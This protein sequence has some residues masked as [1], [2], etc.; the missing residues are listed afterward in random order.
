[1]T[2]REALYMLLITF[3]TGIF[4]ASLYF[5]TYVFEL[6]AMPMKIITGIIAGIALGIM[7]EDIRGAVLSTAIS[8]FMFMACLT[9]LLSIPVFTGV[10]EDVALANLMMLRSMKNSLID[11]MVFLL[12]PMMVLSMLMQYLKERWE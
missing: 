9:V 2:A 8:V 1:M 5:M 10:I 12:I 4:S 7:V 6:P 3:T 11:G